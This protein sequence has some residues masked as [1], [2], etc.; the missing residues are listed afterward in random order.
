[1]SNT[2]LLAII[3]KYIM[4]L[5]NKYLS[6]SVFIKFILDLFFFFYVK[7]DYLQLTRVPRFEIRI[8]DGGARF[9]QFSLRYE[10]KP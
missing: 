2:F 4:Y 3:Q 9:V 8:F 6:K 10:G 7:F 5:Y 1:M